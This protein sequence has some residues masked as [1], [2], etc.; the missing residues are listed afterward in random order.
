MFRTPTFVVYQ[1]V[2]LFRTTSKIHSTTFAWVRP[3]HIFVL[4]ERLNT[5]E[6]KKK[7]RERKKRGHERTKSRHRRTA[8]LRLAVGSPS[9]I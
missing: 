1:L 9:I 3:W 7:E 4:V 6:K 8:I 5:E 2:R